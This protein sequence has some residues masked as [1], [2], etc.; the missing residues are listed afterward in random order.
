M[1]LIFDLD[2]TLIDSDAAL[3][4][5]FHALGVPPEA[6]T[7][8]HLLETECERLGI[9]MAAYLAAYDVTAAPPF[10]G[11]EELVAA[12][13]PPHRWAVCSNKHPSGGVPELAR[14]GWEPELAL[15]SDAFGGATK[16]VGPV[17]DRLGVDASDALFVGDTAHDRAAASAAGVPF[18]LAGWN[19][20]AAAAAQSSDLVAPTPVDVLRFADERAATSGS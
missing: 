13:R 16:S 10:P 4:A 17:L 11:A 8:G 1:L 18:I 5:P 15:F 14:L 6:V 20:R 3:V 19:P 9:D 12:I 7:F 2:G